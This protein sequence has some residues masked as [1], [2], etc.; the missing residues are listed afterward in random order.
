MFHWR[1]QCGM[2]IVNTFSNLPQNYVYSI[3]VLERKANEDWNNLACVMM[4]L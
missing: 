3:A 4:S 1:H 2:G